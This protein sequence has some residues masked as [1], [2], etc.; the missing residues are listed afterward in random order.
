[1]CID[2]IPIDILIINCYMAHIDYCIEFSIYI[3]IYTY[4]YIYI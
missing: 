1:M 4:V 2:N 3:Y